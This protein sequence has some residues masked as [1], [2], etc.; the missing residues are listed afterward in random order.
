MAL[1]DMWR[2]DRDG[3]RKKSLHQILAFAGEGRLTDNNACSKEFR[4]L[5]A[6]IPLDVLRRYATEVLTSD[7]SL[8]QV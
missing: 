6:V 7:M 3:I 4:E 1:I 5:L 8:I 2:E